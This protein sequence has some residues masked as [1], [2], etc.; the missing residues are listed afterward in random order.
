MEQR[1]QWTYN[2]KNTVLQKEMGRVIKQMDGCSRN[3]QWK[4]ILLG[5]RRIWLPELSPYNI[6]NPVFNSNKTAWNR[7]IPQEQTNNEKR[8]DPESVPEE[9]QTLDLL[10]KDFKSGVLNMLK[11][12]KETMDEELKPEWCM[13]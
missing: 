9:V 12:L 13:N 7:P 11:M 10:G 1:L 3:K 8:F 5:Q 4:L 6:Q 2:G